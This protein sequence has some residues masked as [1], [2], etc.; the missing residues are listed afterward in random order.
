MNDD[1]AARKK[2]FVVGRRYRVLA[3]FVQRNDR[4]R[5]GETLRFQRVEWSR[6]D[7]SHIYIFQAADGALKP[8]W[9]SDDDEISRARRH[10]RRVGLFG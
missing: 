6:Y 10:F 5:K 2:L 9:L 4:F 3:D 7:G 8:W 1:R